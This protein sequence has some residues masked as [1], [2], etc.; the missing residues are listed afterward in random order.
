MALIDRI[1]HLVLQIAA[2]L[3]LSQVV[4]PKPIIAVVEARDRPIMK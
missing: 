3:W 1:I 4:L 2:V